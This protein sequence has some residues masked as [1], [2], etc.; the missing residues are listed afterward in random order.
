MDLN[1]KST[2]IFDTQ[3]NKI[4]F[5]KIYQIKNNE[6]VLLERNFDYTFYLVPSQLQNT[7]FLLFGVSS[8]ISKK[9]TGDHELIGPIAQSC[10]FEKFQNKRKQR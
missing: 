3:F 2:H 9:K 5:N 4:V 7:F 8:K 10:K 6:H 1:R